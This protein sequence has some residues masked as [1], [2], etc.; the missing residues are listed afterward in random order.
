MKFKELIEAITSNSEAL[1][2][3]NFLEIEDLKREDKLTSEQIIQLLDAFQH[4]TKIIDYNGYNVL[5]VNL[6]KGSEVYYLM[7]AYIKRNELANKTPFIDAIKSNFFRFCIN[8]ILFITDL[9][10]YF[11]EPFNL[12]FPL[13]QKLG[14]SDSSLSLPSLSAVQ[15]Y[16]F[17]ISSYEYR[18]LTTLSKY[19][20]APLGY[21][22]SHVG[23]LLGFLI[24]LPVALFLIPVAGIG[25]I[26]NGVEEYQNLK[27]Q[28]Q[29]ND[30]Y[31]NE[32][33]DD[34][35][36]LKLN[37]LINDKT[38]GEITTCVE[39]ELRLGP[40]PDESLAT[41]ISIF[42]DKMEE[43]FA[44]NNPLHG[45]AML[46]CAHILDIYTFNSE[47]REEY[48]SKAEKVGKFR[49]GK[50]WQVLLENPPNLKKIKTS[51]ID[52]LFVESKEGVYINLFSKEA[53]PEQEVNTNNEAFEII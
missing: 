8:P 20:T 13:T 44:V 40:L 6:E 27:H 16:G 14:K 23:K 32:C 50:A 1:T 2:V 34:Y 26:Y 37:Y 28:S 25:G 53:R 41:F 48:Y 12:L 15:D 47:L 11:R 52:S 51:E 18:N 9:G 30:E 33:L 29:S 24:S 45:E 3:L 19:V 43:Q 4:N 22:A 31:I 17:A 49:P 10:K 38:I 35:I 46:T 36:N 21:F 42:L 7:N 39:T 5:Y